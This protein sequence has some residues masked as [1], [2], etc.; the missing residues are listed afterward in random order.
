M[1][2]ITPLSKQLTLI[3]REFWEQR[4]AFLLVPLCAVVLAGVAFGVATIRAYLRDE[5]PFNI[6]IGGR[7]FSQQAETA[8]QAMARY[9]QAPLAAKERLWEQFYSGPVPLLSLLFWGIMLYYF[10]TTLYSARKDRSIL[11]WNSMPV[12]SSQTVMSKLIAGLVIT[13][14]VYL[15]AMLGIQLVL[16]G[17]FLVYGLAVDVDLWQNFIAPAHVFAR[18]GW[19]VLFG[20]LNIAWCL[21]VYGWLLFNSAWV[22]SAPLAWAAGPVVVMAIPELIFKDRS[23]ILVK[24]IEHLLPTWM[25]NVDGPPSVYADKLQL[26]LTPELVVSA[27]LGAG[28]VYAAIRFNR[29]EDI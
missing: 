5:T 28:L 17:V 8:A 24:L 7:F 20:I 6:F 4:I 16:L 13:Q 3:K 18:F 2:A 29:S 21:P 25:F 11:F 26:V 10:L 12:S 15:V 23:A 27:F 22:R 19:L 14:A 1:T 9:Q